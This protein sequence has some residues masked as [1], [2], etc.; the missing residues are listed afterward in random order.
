MPAAVAHVTSKQLIV[1]HAEDAPRR[2]VGVHHAAVA[3]EHEH[4]LREH[5]GRDL[6]AVLQHAQ[7]AAPGADLASQPLGCRDRLREALARQIQR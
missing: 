1:A 4:A 2:V 5:L 6:H 3:V 7:L